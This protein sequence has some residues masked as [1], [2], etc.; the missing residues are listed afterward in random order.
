MCHHWHFSFSIFGTFVLF[1]TVPLAFAHDL[2]TFGINLQEKYK[3][4]V[5]N[6]KAFKIKSYDGNS[7]FSKANTYRNG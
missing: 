2:L 6:S 7:D 1:I 5:K 4:M 3:R